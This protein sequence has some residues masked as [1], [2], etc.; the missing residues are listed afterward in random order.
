MFAQSNTMRAKLQGDSNQRADHGFF[1]I[2]DRSICLIATGVIML[3][4]AI[5]MIA[6][7]YYAAE[8]P[9]KAIQQACGETRYFPLHNPPYSNMS[10]QLV[11][12]PRKWSRGRMAAG[13]SA[14]ISIV[15]RF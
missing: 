6:L 10:C 11:T 13:C 7:P 8:L 2:F 15:D 9:E 4:C 14:Y 1:G 5:L 12:P 3:V